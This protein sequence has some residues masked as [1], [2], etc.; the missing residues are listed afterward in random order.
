M[1]VYFRYPKGSTMI[2][3]RRIYGF[4]E[5]H[6]PTVVPWAIYKAFKNSLIQAS[7]TKDVLEQLFP[8]NEFPKLSFTYNEIRFLSWE[9]QCALC[10]AF[11]FTTNRSRDSRRRKL[12]NFMKAYC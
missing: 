5:I 10:K 12:R 1:L 8:G 11:G 9:Q 6:G 7:Y 3:G 4:L 2:N